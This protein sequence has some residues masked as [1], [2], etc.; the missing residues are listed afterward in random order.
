[1]TYGPGYP[2]EFAREALDIYVGSRTGDATAFQ[3]FYV[4]RREEGDVIGGIGYSFPEGPQRPTVGYDIVEP[5]WGRGYATEA[6]TGLLGYLL[7][8]PGI[9]AVQADTLETHIASR[10]VMEKAGM[11]HFDTREG[12]VDGEPATLVYYEVRRP[13]S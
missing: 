6:L 3:P 7:A 10:C 2:S 5:L 13:E 11:T 8:L 1:M 4:I 12:D 9:E